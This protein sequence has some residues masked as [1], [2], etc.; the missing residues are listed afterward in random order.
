MKR[1]LFLTSIPSVHMDRWYKY[2]S[3]LEDIETKL[4]V[5][6]EYMG[7]SIFSKIRYIF[8]IKAKILN[9]IDEY[10]PDVIN[11]H[12][13]FFPNYL[14]HNMINRKIVITPWNGDIIHYKY[15]KH[16]MW[17]SYIK[18]LAKMVKRNQIVKSLNS[19]SL[20]TYNSA[21][22]AKEINRLLNK[23]V[24]CEYVQVPGIDTEKWI[25]AENKYTSRNLTGIPLD[26]FVIL[27]S[28]Q[29]GGIYN[30][31]IIVEAA[32]DLAKEE[33]DIL[34]V[35]IVPVIDKHTKKFMQ[36]ISR[37][38]LDGKVK[39]VTHVP[40]SM[41]LNY[42]QAS[43][44][45]ISISSKDSCPQTV[46][47][48]MSTKLPMIV[49]DIDVLRDLVKDNYGGLLTPCR[50]ANALKKNILKLKN[51]AVMRN[52]LGEHGREIVVKYHDYYANM[53][54]METL[55]DNL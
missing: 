47:E 27:S 8:S 26:K 52:D 5:C 22:M 2:F 25:K 3:D 23:R 17:L 40:H 43:D 54:K 7:S 9:I 6:K 16:L 35:F 37:R 32:A 53:A 46:L 12:T 42:Y 15:D 21:I 20:I 10:D 51:N 31:D 18:V 4:V 19:A 24:P 1:Y 39:I 38:K 45:G 29:M 14:F 30:I 50:D 41:M 33:K 11:M 36:N 48:G 13:V 49:G 55:M 34:F 44:V 28:R